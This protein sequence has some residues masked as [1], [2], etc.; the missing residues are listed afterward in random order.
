MGLR[1]KNVGA[2]EGSGA[3]PRVKGKKRREVRREIGGRGDQ[4]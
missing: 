1:I 4:K 2:K 3:N